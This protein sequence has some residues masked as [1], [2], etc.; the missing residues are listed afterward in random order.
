MQPRHTVGPPQEPS[1]PDQPLSERLPLT[2]PEPRGPL[3]EWVLACLRHGVASDRCPH[4]ADDARDIDGLGEDAQLALYL[5]YELHFGDLPGVP[6]S[7]EWNPRLIELRLLLEASME[8]QLRRLVQRR[9]ANA[10]VARQITNLVEADTGPSISRFMEE[11]G[12]LEQMREFVIHRAAYQRK[13]GDGHTF[14]IPRVG[15]RAKQLLVQIQSGEYGA[16]EADREI[17]AQLFAN[18]MEAL[19]L[20]SRTNAYLDRQPGAA[21]AISN[22]ISMFGLNRRWRGALLGHL[23]VF[24]TTSV[25]PMGRYARALRRMGAPEVAARFYDVHV[26]ADA[27]HEVMVMDAVRELV[28]AEPSCAQDVIFGAQCALAVETRFAE[29]L[30]SMWRARRAS[31]GIA[32]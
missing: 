30:L 14:A 10:D 32:A 5:C 17:H 9:R 4:V 19:G 7:M 12:E 16:D 29:G 21:L 8:R 13:E 15:G 28:A 18:T 27:E 23:A 6:A 3:S 31:D 2:L 24:E 22:L 26:L 1:T 25:Q 11:V 20:D